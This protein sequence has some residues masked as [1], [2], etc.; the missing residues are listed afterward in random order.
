MK[1]HLKRKGRIRKRAK[2][3]EYA[4]DQSAYLKAIRELINAHLRDRFNNYVLEI[5]RW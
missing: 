2:T 4:S 3:N 5:K 1:K